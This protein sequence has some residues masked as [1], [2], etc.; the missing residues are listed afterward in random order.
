MLSVKYMYLLQPPFLF[1]FHCKCILVRWA[2]LKDL[3]LSL[4]LFSSIFHFPVLYSVFP[5]S[6]MFHF[7]QTCFGFLFR[8]YF[9]LKP[10]FIS[11]FVIKWQWIL[12]RSLAAP[13]SSFVPKYFLCIVFFSIYTVCNF[14]FFC[15][16]CQLSV[17]MFC[18]LQSIASQCMI[19]CGLQWPAVVVFHKNYC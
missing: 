2:L 15:F 17:I 16:M 11:K 9:L 8:I 12:T 4:C 19:K 14:G 18:N 5:L 13:F 10:I 1:Y 7:Y 6:S 3:C